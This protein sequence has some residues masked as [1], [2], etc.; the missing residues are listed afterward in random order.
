MILR[1]ICF[2]WEA[3]VPTGE[4]PGAQARLLGC[5]PCK[6]HS[7]GTESAHKCLGGWEGA[8]GVARAGGGEGGSGG[9]RRADWRGIVIASLS[10]FSG[11]EKQIKEQMLS[12]HL[13]CAR[14]WLVVDDGGFCHHLALKSPGMEADV[15]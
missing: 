14:H 2:C 7:A 13:P 5:I 8:Q 10:A 1:R 6:E 12:E 11:K 3:S 9:G 15:P 4:L